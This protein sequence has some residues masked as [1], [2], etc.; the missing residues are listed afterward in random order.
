MNI[1][2]TFAQNT[3][4]QKTF[5]KNYNVINNIE[6]TKPIAKATPLAE[7]IKSLGFTVVEYDSNTFQESIADN[8]EDKTIFI[9]AFDSPFRKRYDTAYLLGVALQPDATRNEHL[10]FAAD[11]LMPEATI[12]LAVSDYVENLGKSA[13]TFP[14]FGKMIKALSSIFE[15]NPH[16]IDLRLHQI[17][18]TDLYY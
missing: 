5:G 18:G 10:A 6:M 12:K 11:L 4:I 15:I 14:E 1:A 7:I 16:A 13:L 8:A 2:E 3:R 9:N 17:L